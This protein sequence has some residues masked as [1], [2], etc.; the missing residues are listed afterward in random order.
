MSSASHQS[1]YKRHEGCWRNDPGPLRR[2]T[3][4]SVEFHQI[5]SVYIQHV[6]RRDRERTTYFNKRFVFYFD[7]ERPPS[8]SP[9]P[10]PGSRHL[11]TIPYIEQGRGGTIYSHGKFVTPVSKARRCPFCP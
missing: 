6:E 1:R 8:A 2:Y 11:V 10:S 5:L 9:H 3:D 7:K 4:Q